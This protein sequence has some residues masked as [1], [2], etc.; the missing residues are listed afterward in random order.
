MN[1]KPEYNGDGIAW[2]IMSK[3]LKR[4]K[5]ATGCESKDK[6][7]RKENE[8]T[9]EGGEKT[10]GKKLWGRTKTIPRLHRQV[11]R[12]SHPRKRSYYHTIPYRPASEDRNMDPPP[13][14]WGA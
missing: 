14:V 1:T 11:Q 3:V 6:E 9:V 10:C 12:S 2:G 5:L 8:G 13:R 4:W 7:G